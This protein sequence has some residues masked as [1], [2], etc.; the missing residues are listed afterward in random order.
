MSA[1]TSLV[2]RVCRPDGSSH[3]GFQ[4]PMTVGAEVVA[5]D[6]KAN[7]ECG[8]GLHGW[9][10]G[11]GEHDCVSHWE[12]EHAN[13]LVLEVES[14][15]IQ[16]LVGKCKFERCVLRFVGDKAEA[17]AYLIKHEPQAASVAV[18]GAS[19]QVGDGAAA[20]VGALGT[21]TAG[22]KGTATAGDSG[23]AT[24]GNSGT[25][26]AGYKG[27]ATAGDLGTA[28]A[29]DKGTATAGYKG[30][31]TA[32]DLGTA[33]AGNSGTATAGETGE[34]RIRYWDYKAERYRTAI[35]YVGEDG[36][37]A[38][39]AYRLDDNHKFVEVQP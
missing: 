32:G 1:K 2:L 11:H 38:G 37:E 16:M 13:W 18:I 3:G 10:Y 23:T 21:A 31:A 9:L 22:Y 26:T 34:L 35:A 19:L 4:W 30:T 17:A 7:T 5:P 28:T 15:G 29:G 39:T 6:W 25:A 14:A 12:H 33:T 36:I 8:N 20:A 27:T 24:A